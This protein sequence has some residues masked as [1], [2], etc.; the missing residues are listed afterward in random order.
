MKLGKTF[1]T[2]IGLVAKEAVLQ[3]EVE[4]VLGP[5]K[6]EVPKPQL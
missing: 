6:T 2:G 1:H 4:M 5:G 3:N